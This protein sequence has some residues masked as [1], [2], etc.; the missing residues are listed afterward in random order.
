MNDST[1]SLNATFVP[2][3]ASERREDLPAGLEGG[4]VVEQGPPPSPTSMSVALPL[5]IALI[6]AGLTL[7]FIKSF[8]KICNPNEILII[9]GRKHRNKSGKEVG[10]QVKFG[11]RAIVIP[12]IE[13]VKRMDLT[14]MPVPVEVTNAY[15]KGG[16]P[17]NIQAIANVKIS[18][19]ERVVG[20]AIERFL[21][22]SRN[23]I[24]R[25]ARET[26]E[27]NL[28]GV[29][30]TLT[31]EEINEDR[32]QF[33]ER[34][35]QDV[36]RDLEKLG[37]HLDTLKIQ[38]VADDVDYLS[39]IG[40][41]RIAQIVR[42]AEIAESQALGQAERIE[43]ECQQRA[44]IAKTEALSLVQQ[45]QNE[46]RTIKAELEQEARSEEERTTAA[47]KEA[48][49]RAEQTLQ[50]VRAELERLRL[51][52][53]EVLPAEAHS[54]S[55][56]LHAKGA[57]AALAEN[58]KAAAKVNEMLTQVWANTGTSA[59]EV[60]LIQQLEMILKQAAEI[61]NRVQIDR[62]NVIDT[63][64]GQAIA[65][66]VNAYPEMVRQFLERV[67]QTLGIQLMKSPAASKAQTLAAS[68]ETVPSKADPSD[69]FPGAE[70]VGPNN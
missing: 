61:P 14:T 6:A 4:L 26:L 22:R 56:E 12:V 57:A 64:N 51:E 42:D 7:W 10:Y 68:L 55:Q 11:G 44:E 3:F 47:G 69:P 45:K 50:K 33:A 65:G 31:P 17:L 19:D 27:G 40:R 23:E 36:S 5:V 46:L 58:A 54:R 66:L 2:R 24:K 29:V 32:L 21:D 60:F 39:S 20:N 28:R 8:L 9:S 63:G 18:G 30:A 67:D 1:L 34:I 25:V 52:A 43:A 15:S 70:A 13:T 37:L 53:D 62:I 48:R 59:S 16:T 35:A 38:S 49:A 41:R